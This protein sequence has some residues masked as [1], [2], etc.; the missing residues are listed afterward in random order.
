MAKGKQVH[1]VLRGKFFEFVRYPGEG[2][3]LRQ[4]S[5][6]D[7]SLDRLL[8]WLDRWRTTG[9]HVRAGSSTSGSPAPV[10]DVASL[11]GIID[12][13]YDVI[14]GPAGTALDRS[15]DVWLHHP[16]A[17]VA[18]TGVR[19][20]GAGHRTGAD[21]RLASRARRRPAERTSA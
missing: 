9:R 11:D 14:S 16:E 21:R 2:H 3:S 19:S 1:T 6:Q 8:A 4:A 15:R 13:W 20:G 17:R 5:V 7:D 18:M 12:A 10:D